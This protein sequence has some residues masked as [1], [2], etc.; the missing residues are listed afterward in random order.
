MSTYYDAL[1]ASSPTAAAAAAGAVP[2]LYRHHFAAGAGVDK[3]KKMIMAN[4][5]SADLFIARDAAVTS[6]PD[7]LPC[8][9]TKN[10]ANGYFYS[11]NAPII[12]SSSNPD[13]STSVAVVTEDM[14][15]DLDIFDFHSVLYRVVDIGNACPV[16]K[17]FTEEIQTRQ[18]R[19]PEVIL[20]AGYDTTADMWSLAC[21]LYELA[22][23]DYLFDPR[24][25]DDFPRDED[26]IARFIETLGP[27]PKSLSVRGTKC[28]T[29]LN[30]H[31]E[32]R[33]IKPARQVD[34]ATVLVK[35]FGWDPSQASYFASF[36][37]PMLE[38][39]PC[40]RATARQML[41]HSWLTDNSES[42]FNPLRVKTPTVATAQAAAVHGHQQQ[43]HS[44]SFVYGRGFDYDGKLTMMS[45]SS[46]S[47]G[48]G[49]N[50]N[51]GNVSSSY[52][53]L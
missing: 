19:S 51:N 17:H 32:P 40:N 2:A 18:Y 53:N 33:H 38:W 12:S 28:R 49:S 5:D 22:T 14:I 26:H 47:Y 52:N 29:Y 1:S 4:V 9:L 25:G 3:Q 30:R 13:A 11:A 36:L 44:S 34:I 45:S 43:Q 24:S 8:L 15:H 23:G 27:M 41:R 7:S 48:G 21:M 31:G 10:T 42:P 39:E 50:N 46:S 20:G 37:M 35:H 16:E 6:G